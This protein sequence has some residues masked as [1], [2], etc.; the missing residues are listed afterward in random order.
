MDKSRPNQR[1]LKANMR[2]AYEHFGILFGH[3][4]AS[5]F[6]VTKQPPEGVLGAI[7]K[8][9]YFSETL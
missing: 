6:L 2:L 5:C 4:S 3:F 9:C 7:L 1:C 8:N